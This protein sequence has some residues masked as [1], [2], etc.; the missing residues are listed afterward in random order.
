LDNHPKHISQQRYFQDMDLLKDQL[1]V[2]EFDC[3]VCMKR[4]GLFPGAYMSFKLDIPLFTTSELGSIPDKFKNVLLLDDKV[5]SGK[6][7]RHW[8]IKLIM[9]QKKAITAAVYL[10]NEY[11]TD[12]YAVDLGCQHTMFYE[13]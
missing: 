12:L 3:I 6:S 11:K 13:L 4:S 8:L 1:A 10:Q 7:M 5:Y 9:L 2:L